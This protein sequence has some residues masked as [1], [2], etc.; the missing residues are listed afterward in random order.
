MKE[1]IKVAVTDDHQLI[2]NGLKDILEA[3]EG[4][5]FTSGFLNIEETRKG[6]ETNIPDV[7]LLDVN[8]PDG[9]GIEFCKEITKDHPDLKVIALTSYDQSIMVKNMMRNGAQGYL[10]KNTSKEE[11]LKAIKTVNGGGRFLQPELEKQ[12]LDESFGSSRQ[13]G[14]IPTLTRREKEV[15]NLIMEELTSA[16]IGE[17]LFISQKTVETH[18]LNLIQKMGVRNTA[19]LVKE[20]INKGMV[21]Q[22]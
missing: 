5:K 13:Q 12:L 22:G 1:L 4:V 8:L 19:G 11:L 15:L 10:L 3:S 18:R 6:L 7:L 16:E 2:L 20:A 9:D 17:K 14:Y 21:D